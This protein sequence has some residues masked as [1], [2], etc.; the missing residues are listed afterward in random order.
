[1]IFNLIASFAIVLI[2]Y[3]VYNFFARNFYQGYIDGILEYRLSEIRQRNPY[4]YLRIKKM[5]EDKELIIKGLKIVRV[6][7]E[8]K[9]AK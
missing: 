8:N 9:A 3:L 4:I 1:M 2:L 7:K 6:K 5:F